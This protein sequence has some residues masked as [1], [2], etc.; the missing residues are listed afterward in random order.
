MY[1]R[2]HIYHFLLSNGREY[3]GKVLAHDRDKIVISAL[4]RAEQPRRMI[5]YQN[6][7]VMAERMDG[8]GF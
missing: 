8:R 6:S 2:I 5:L 3:Y 7:M 4:R 1:D